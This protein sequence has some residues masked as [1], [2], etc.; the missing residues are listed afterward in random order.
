MWLSPPGA[1]AARGWEG[2]HVASSIMKNKKNLALFLKA[3]G[4][5]GI[6]D[7]VPRS[8]RAWVSSRA[9]QCCPQV[10][11]ALILVP[12]PSPSVWCECSDGGTQHRQR[13]ALLP[14]TASSP[15]QLISHR[16]SKAKN[17]CVLVIPQD[18]F[19]HPPGPPLCC[20]LLPTSC[21]HTRDQR[22]VA[23]QGPCHRDAHL[24]TRSGCGMNF[25]A[26]CR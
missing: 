5:S 15:L 19:D 10:S 6:P 2:D 25:P 14:S 26:A 3:K 24:P 1:R 18:I 11:P 16:K 9:G 22:A 21:S 12:A 20:H 7:L 4:C 17:T 23:E 8:P 13:T